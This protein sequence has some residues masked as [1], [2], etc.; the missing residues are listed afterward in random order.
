MCLQGRRCC[1]GEAGSFLDHDAGVLPGDGAGLQRIECRR[2]PRGQCVGFSKEGGCGALADGEHARDFGYQAHLSRRRL[3]RAGRR[4]LQLGRG[5]RVGGQERTFAAAVA[6]STRASIPNPS[7]HASEKS[8]NGS[9]SA[10][11]TRIGP[12]GAPAGQATTPASSS[13]SPATDATAAATAA[14]PPASTT[15]LVSITK[16]CQRGL[17]FQEVSVLKTGPT[18]AFTFPDAPAPPPWLAQTRRLA[19]LTR[20]SGCRSTGSPRRRP[21]RRR[22]AHC[23][24]APQPARAQ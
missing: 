24:R 22:A 12:S 5:L 14:L 18:T 8:C 23:R 7:R 6:A 4:A 20:Q 17:T 13:T 3:I 16:A 19:Q 10:S 2:Q 1:W 11:G 15:R 9:E 21:P